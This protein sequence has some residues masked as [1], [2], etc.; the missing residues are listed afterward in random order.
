MTQNQLKVALVGCGQIADAHLQQIRTISHAE[1]V[2]VCDRHIDLARQAAER[3]E[4]DLHTD[5]LD[6]M[7]D[8]ARPD[9]V[10]ITSPP[11]SHAAIARQVLAAGA[12]VY[13]E[14]PFTV[15]A[16]EADEILDDARRHQRLVCVGHDQLFD[17]I[18]LRYRRRFQAAEFG[19][20]VHVDSIMGYDLA[21]PFGKNVAEEPDHWVH[22][23]PG[24][25]FQNTIPHALY[26]V[27]E[28]LRDADPRI[29]ATWFADQEKTGFPT[30]LRVMLQGAD[31]SGTLL[32]SSKM[33]PTQRLVRVLGTHG[34][35]EMNF[36]SSVLTT[37]RTPRLR[38]SLAKLEL[39][40]G[41]VQESLRGFLVNIA[42]TFRNELHYFAGMQR[43]FEL[44]YQAIRKGG[45]PP[46]A[47]DEIR[48][49]TA[50]MDRVFERC[51]E[52]R[53]DEQDHRPARNR[54]KRLT[55]EP[56]AQASS[57]ACAAGSSTDDFHR[58]VA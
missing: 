52:S 38:G 54:G 41:N 15:N 27:T 6:Q 4:V 58:P 57:L 2:A 40:V 14:K 49:V 19:E 10:H 29:W 33:R 42:K 39:G 32:F 5:N 53:L 18:W 30:E 48:R 8:Q 50:L 12:H 28:H 26:K 25:L 46:F 23:L 44:F 1:V 35:I 45:E 11:A 9:V 37:C 21:G 55:H 13:I 7:L 16:Q 24:G 31:V 43:L 56:A 34:I 47:Y 3:F 20:V 51:Q 36:D 17:D 22:R